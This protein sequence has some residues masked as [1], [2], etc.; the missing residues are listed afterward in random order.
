MHKNNET[1]AWDICKMGSYTKFYGIT[2]KKEIIQLQEARQ[3]FR[4]AITIIIAIVYWGATTCQAFLMRHFLSD[5]S[6]TN[7]CYYSQLQRK[8][9][10]TFSFSIGREGGGS[11]FSGARRGLRN[12]FHSWKKYISLSQ[13]QQVSP[14]TS[15][16]ALIVALMGQCSVCACCFSTYVWGKNQ[17]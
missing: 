6:L 16:T 17:S 1:T 5:N 11:P 2:G 7:K 14:Q 4:A 9:A 15:S 8:M 10:F 12:C 3:D 13:P